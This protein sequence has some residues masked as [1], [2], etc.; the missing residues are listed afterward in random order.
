ML[1]CAISKYYWRDDPYTL[2]SPNKKLTH[3]FVQFVKR[4]QSRFYTLALISKSYVNIYCS[5]LRVFKIDLVVSL[6]S[7]TN[8]QSFILVLSLLLLWLRVTFVLN[9]LIGL[10][11]LFFHGEKFWTRT[12][13]KY[14]DL[15]EFETIYGYTKL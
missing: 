2:K 6:L 9:T 12:R 1:F 5:S 8:R 15:G 10:K 7:A 14:T 11:K 3:T 13:S 4:L